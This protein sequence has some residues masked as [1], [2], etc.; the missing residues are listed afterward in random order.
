M[1][2]TAKTG[3]SRR[4]GVNLPPE[5][6]H[7]P[8]GSADGCVRRQRALLGSANPDDWEW[9]LE[10]S[11]EAGAIVEGRWMRAE[12]FLGFSERGLL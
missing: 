11:G 6:P 7:R 9:W 1:T 8:S 2:E 3:A 12:K 5:L 4:P 10:V